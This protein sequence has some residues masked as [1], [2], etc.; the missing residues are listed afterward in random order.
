MAVFCSV[1]LR[2]SVPPRATKRR[3]ANLASIQFKQGGRLDELVLVVRAPRL[4]AS[5]AVRR[6]VVADDV[7][8]LASTPRLQGHEESQ[9]LERALRGRIRQKSLLA[10]RWSGASICVSPS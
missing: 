9:E 10:A 8:L 2:W 5:V 4:D 6:R 7:Q 1:W 3:A